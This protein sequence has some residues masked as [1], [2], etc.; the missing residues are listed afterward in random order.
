LHPWKKKKKKICL[1]NKLNVTIGT[2]QIY[3]AL[4]AVKKRASNETKGHCFTP[5]NGNT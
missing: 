5:L 4:D 3:A 1:L 2:H